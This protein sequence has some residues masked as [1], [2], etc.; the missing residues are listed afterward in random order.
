MVAHT[1]Y[2]PS[3]NYSQKITGH[4]DGGHCTESWLVLTVTLASFEIVGF[5]I[6]NTQKMLIKYLAALTFPDLL[7]GSLMDSGLPE[8]GVM[9][10]FRP[11]AS[12]PGCLSHV[13]DYELTW[14]QVTLGPEPH[15]LS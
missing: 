2:W 8:C 11:R 1:L 4:A 9:Y 12:A 7:V 15:T 10:S 14:S 5:P 13:L 6:S 3:S